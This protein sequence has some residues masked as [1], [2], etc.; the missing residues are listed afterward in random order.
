MRF[1]RGRVVDVEATRGADRMRA[2]LAV[3]PGAARLGEIALVD[4]SSVVGQSGLVFNY[5]LIDEN[6]TCHIALGDAY[7]HTM[8]DLP[9][10]PDAQVALGFNRSACHDDVM[11]G[12]PEVDVWG[13][14]ANG[15]EVPV[16]VEDLWVL[17]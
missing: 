9:D 10:D 17:T 7:P 16:I 13:I 4:G 14:D 1:E 12:G 2:E 15:D 8:P 6:A 5:G 3:D 11:I